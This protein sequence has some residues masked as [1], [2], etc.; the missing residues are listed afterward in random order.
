MLQLSIMS[1]EYIGLNSHTTAQLVEHCTGKAKV[2]GSN[3]VQILK[4]FSG[5]FSSGVMAAFTSF[6]LSFL[7]V[8]DTYYHS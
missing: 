8:L 4:I 3:P 6:I 1:T 2:V 5:H 7:L